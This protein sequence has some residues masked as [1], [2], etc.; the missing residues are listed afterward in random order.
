[1]SGV[2]H[3]GPEPSE[4]TPAE[5]ASGPAPTA[6]PGSADV[7][8]VAAPAPRVQKP[9]VK[10]SVVLALAIVI[11]FFTGISGVAI[12]AASS[13]DGG[14]PGITGPADGHR[15]PQII[16]PADRTRPPQTLEPDD[17]VPEAAPSAAAN[18][19]PA[20]AATGES[21]AG[22]PQ[23]GRDADRGAA[24][25]WATVA[26]PLDCPGAPFD[27]RDARPLGAEGRTYVVQVRC[28]AGS[29]TAPDGLYTY[30]LAPNGGAALVGTLLSPGEDRLVKEFAVRDG[31]IQATLQGWSTDDVP[32]CCPDTEETRVLTP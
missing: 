9:D 31:K 7:L 15:E 19:T 1:M 12:W 5:T 22:Q 6:P 21:R 20:G 8:R 16:E 13:F 3:N 29:G 24:V 27:V 10:N 32:R 14:R 4:T 11:L 17:A 28:A 18:A 30:A 26:Y 2:A 25:D 23:T